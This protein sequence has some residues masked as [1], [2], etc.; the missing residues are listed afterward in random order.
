VAV[1]GTAVNLITLLFGMGAGAALA[2]AVLYVLTWA[3]GRSVQVELEQGRS[4]LERTR[5]ISARGELAVALAHELSQP[6]A[7]IL[8]NAEAAELYLETPT[9]DLAELRAIVAD[10]RRDG[11]RAGELITRMRTL[12]KSRKVEM[13]ALAPE[14]LVR[15]AMQL[16]R[17][18][19]AARQ[20]TLQRVIAPELPLVSGDRVH[21]SQVLLNLMV[22]GM[23]AMESC[24]AGSRRLV[25]EAQR[26]DRRMVEVI[27][28]DSGPGVGP[29]L[30]DRI[31]D[32]FFT[33]KSEGL[34]VGLAVSRTIIEAH[35]G[36]L[37]AESKATGPG[38]TFHFTLPLA[39]KGAL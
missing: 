39:C 7:A 28:S 8:R 14:E 24:P 1:D 38:L 5:R 2:L 22:N 10:I 17:A 13:Q 9:P 36:K 27:V 30:V 32:P 19:A 18:E 33:T 20:V 23:D 21:I 12:I 4:E 16:A 34:G 29:D 25:I 6:V 37:W 35:G 31:F 26:R 15:D 3:N 11:M